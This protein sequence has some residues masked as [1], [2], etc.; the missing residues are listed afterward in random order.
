MHRPVSPLLH[1]Y[2]P[3][4]SRRPAKSKAFQWFA[5]G[6]GIP[7]V[8]V[9]LI[10]GLYANDPLRCRE[11]TRFLGA[12][13]DGIVEEVEDYCSQDGPVYAFKVLHTF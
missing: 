9:A 10:G 5:V 13:I 8:A 7:L 4:A 12:T 6:L 11:R 3:S 1:D 2:K